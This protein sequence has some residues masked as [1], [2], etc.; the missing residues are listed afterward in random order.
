MT[1]KK[2]HVDLNPFKKLNSFKRSIKKFYKQ[3]K[4]DEHG[5]KVLSETVFLLGAIFQR[6]RSQHE[7]LRIWLSSALISNFEAN[8]GQ[9]SSKK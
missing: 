8:R 3:T 6:F 5:V 2:I 1:F 9:N 4:F 7:I